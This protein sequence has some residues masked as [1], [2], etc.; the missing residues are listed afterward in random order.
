MPWTNGCCSAASAST[1]FRCH[2]ES[3]SEATKQACTLYEQLD[4]R[5]AAGL[6]SAGATVATVAPALLVRVRSLEPEGLI[7]IKTR[8][9]GPAHAAAL[10]ADA[11]ADKVLKKLHSG[12]PANSAPATSKT[13]RA[14]NNPP[15]QPVSAIVNHVHACAGIAGFN[16]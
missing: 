11:L 15:R 14:A 16:A 2:S 9:T 3:D 5:V 4:D 8:L 6:L 13:T 1:R 10:D 12:R 7:G